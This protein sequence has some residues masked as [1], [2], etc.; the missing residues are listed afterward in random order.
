MGKKIVVLTGSPRKNGNSAALA[1]TFIKAAERNGCQVAR[2]DAAE[3]SVK[4]CRGCRG[5]YSKGRACVFD[6]DFNKV[7]PALE[8]ADGVVLV[9]PV[10]WY[11]FP[12]CLKAVIDKFYA[13]FVGGK[14][15]AGKKCALLACCADK[16]VSTF[17]GMLVTWR[18]TIK[19]M[20]GE[21]V[22]EVLVPGV[23]KAGDIKAADGLKQ[24]E[25]LAEKFA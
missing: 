20:R 4:E 2:F 24:A 17:D 1:E 22:G 10:Y 8:A 14:F 9:T 11:S 25:A 6:D 3:L 23:A 21:M 13:L 19:L 7:A 16:P 5:C 18:E 15:F 12:A